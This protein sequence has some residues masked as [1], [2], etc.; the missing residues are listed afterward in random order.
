MA[1]Y[2]VAPTQPAERRTT[3]PRSY[4]M[5]QAQWRWHREL[6]CPSVRGCPLRIEEAR[7]D[8]SLT[9]KLTVS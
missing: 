8:R 7:S 1:A 6:A 9:L 4:Q 2:D 3:L 5:C